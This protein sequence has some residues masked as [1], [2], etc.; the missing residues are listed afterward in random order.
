MKITKIW[1]FAFM[2]FASPFLL[3]SGC[4][5]KNDDNSTNNSQIETGTM[6][7]IEGNVYTTVKIGTQWWMAENLKTTK[8]NDGMDITQVTEYEAWRYLKTPAFCWFE[9]DPDTYKNKYG[10][11]YNWYS[12]NT[13]KLA[14]AGWHVPSEAEWWTLINYLGGWQVAGGKMKC[15]G[16]IE[17]GTGP[18]YEPNTGATNESGFSAVPTGA[19]EEGGNFIQQ[20]PY[21]ADWWAATEADFNSAF[22]C[23]IR[24]N[25]TTAGCESDGLV[26][27]SGLSIR[28][29]KD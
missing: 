29:V 3:M 4:K 19:R 23:I 20:T 2:I 22:E 15:T 27:S 25:H 21:E 26:K 7:D 5:K 18:W 14:P 28:C 12:I 1:I 10:A 8:Y 6:T 11:L 24:Y 9:N 13:G 16:T 17:A